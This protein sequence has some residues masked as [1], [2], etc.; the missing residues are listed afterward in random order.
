MFR[1]ETCEHSALS[2]VWGEN[3]N[4]CSHGYLRHAPVNIQ[5]RVNSNSSQSIVLLIS[6][7]K[8]Q[9][10]TSQSPDQPPPYSVSFQFQ[11]LIL[12]AESLCAFRTRGHPSGGA[13]LLGQYQ[14]L[15]SSRRDWHA[16]LTSFEA[17]FVPGGVLARHTKWTNVAPAATHSMRTLA[18]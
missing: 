6:Y 17:A 13:F 16:L 10:K 18:I 11:L 14:R 15:W 9:K 1:K 4:R 5:S 8:S 12:A 2:Y 3:R 7:N